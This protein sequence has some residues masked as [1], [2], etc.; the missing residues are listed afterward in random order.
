MTSTEIKL[1]KEYLI[2]NIS[3]LQEQ[4]LVPFKSKLYLAMNR[5][6]VKPFS[7][8]DDD[9]YVLNYNVLADFIVA[10]CKDIGI[11]KASVGPMILQ[12]NNPYSA[13]IVFNYLKAFLSKHSIKLEY[14]KDLIFSTHIHINSISIKRTLATCCI[15]ACASQGYVFKRNA[16]MLQKYYLASYILDFVPSYSC[17]GASS[18]LNIEHLSNRKYKI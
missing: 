8:R 5:D 12:W 3:S 15:S 18:V 16:R 11:Y 9:T 13:N 1:S 6:S 2:R 4:D 7:R 17:G 10:V 14:H